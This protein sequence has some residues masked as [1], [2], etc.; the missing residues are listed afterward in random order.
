VAE[1][2]EHNAIAFAM[3]G[4]IDDGV[5]L[6]LAGNLLGLGATFGALMGGTALLLWQDEKL[7]H[8]VV[9]SELAEFFFGKYRIAARAAR[10]FVEYA[11]PGYDPGN[12]DYSHLARGVLAPP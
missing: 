7:T 1:E 3:L 6:R 11:R 2:I 5:L 8:P 4:A 12:A 10:L 9:R